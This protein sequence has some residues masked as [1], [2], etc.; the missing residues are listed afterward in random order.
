MRTLTDIEIEDILAG[1][2]PLPDDV[3]EAS[4]RRVEQARTL[5]ARLR[6]A[7]QAMAAPTALAG[8]IRAVI[9]DAPANNSA[10]S[11]SRTLRFPAAFRKL[12]PAVAAAAVLVVAIGFWVVGGGTSQA[13]A[14]PELA[15][16]HET[17]IAHGNDFVPCLDGTKIARRMQQQ[18]G[19][20]IHLPSLPASCRFA[21]STLA[22]FRDTTVASA[23]LETGTGPVSIITIRDS[24]E[25]LGFSHTQPV[26]ARTF[27]TCHHD[28]CRMAAVNIDGLTFIATGEVD[29]ERLINLLQTFAEAQSPQ[30]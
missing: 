28:N 22:K 29:H 19:H 25:S 6:D 18:T 2:E 20:D 7:G 15:A 10:E 30:Q 12:A 11:P 26:G 16:I 27:Y 17:N 4:R 23:V 5:Q 14:Q 9:G 8:S 3:D 21:G 13:Y 24:A 1:R